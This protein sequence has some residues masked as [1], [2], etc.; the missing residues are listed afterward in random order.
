MFDVVSS[1]PDGEQYEVVTGLMVLFFVC[2]ITT[3]E[4]L[5]GTLRTLFFMDG[6]VLTAKDVSQL[7]DCVGEVC[8][9]EPWSCS[10]AVDGYVACLSAKGVVEVIAL[11]M[12]AD[13]EH[14][15]SYAHFV[16]RQAGVIADSIRQSFGAK[17]AFNVTFLWIHHKSN[18]AIVN[19]KGAVIDISFR[20]C[21]CTKLRDSL[22]RYAFEALQSRERVY[23]GRAEVATGA[24]GQPFTVMEYFQEMPHRLALT[25]A[26][27]SHKLTLFRGRTLIKDSADAAELD[28]DVET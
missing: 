27:G 4:F 6:D 15:D 3:E 12:T 28:A 13:E 19:G 24:A 23:F 8:Y 9:F 5:T 26:K 20:R 7:K 25:K 10:R 14:S 17:V 11:Q 21:N 22:L 16:H 18:L 1:L 2:H